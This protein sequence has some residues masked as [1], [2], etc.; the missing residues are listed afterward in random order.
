MGGV[1]C[2]PLLTFHTL[3]SVFLFYFPL[4]FL[5]PC[6]LFI[7]FGVFLAIASCFV[8]YSSNREN[9]AGKRRSS[10]ALTCLEMEFF[11]VYIGSRKIQG[12]G[13]KK[14]P[15]FFIPPSKMTPLFSI[16]HFPSFASSR[17]QQSHRHPRAHVS[18]PPIE[19][20]S[21]HLV[22]NHDTLIFS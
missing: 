18:N 7:F 6:P 22:S 15:E 13:K 20:F 14:P 5:L 19:K 4:R 16:A 8:L 3:W 21:Y 11:D 12:N 10:G 2:F 1:L 9:R 17:T